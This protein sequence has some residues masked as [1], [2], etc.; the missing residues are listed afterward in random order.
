VPKFDDEP[1]SL[2]GVSVESANRVSGAFTPTTR[3]LFK[4]DDRVRAV[5]QIYQGTARTDALLPI[6]VRV[7]ILA[8]NGASVRAQ[9]LPFP[10]STFAN[11]RAECVITLPLSALDPGEY[12]LKLEASGRSRSSSRALRFRV[13]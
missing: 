5:L 6:D 12:L 4:R 10:E 13:E 9:S 2:S 1:M 3:R 8:S 7:S 11:R